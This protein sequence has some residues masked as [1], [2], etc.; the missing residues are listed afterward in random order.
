MVFA[1]LHKSDLS[2]H[3]V[4]SKNIWAGCNLSRRP[5]QTVEMVQASTVRAQCRYHHLW[6]LWAHVATPWTHL[7]NSWA[8]ICL[9]GWSLHLLALLWTL[10]LCLLIWQHRPT[11]RLHSGHN[12]STSWLLLFLSTKTAFMSFCLSFS[13]CSLCHVLFSLS[14]L[15]SRLG[16]PVPGLGSPK[17]PT[18]SGH[19]IYIVYTM[20]TLW[21][22]WIAGQQVSEGHWAFFFQ[23]RKGNT[24]IITSWQFAFER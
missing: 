11:S 9:V 12:P 3:G 18:W 13:V 10:L 7:S 5:L 17:D 20:Q 2:V 4:S 6:I 16:S 15:H 1:A 14:C 21:T 24:G 8:S 22:V 19:I 23:C